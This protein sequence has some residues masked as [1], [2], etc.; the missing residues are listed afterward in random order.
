MS[1]H[2]LTNYIGYTSLYRVAGKPGEEYNQMCLLFFS[3]Y[4]KTE[5]EEIELEETGHQPT[6]HCQSR[7]YCHMEGATQSRGTTR[8]LLPPVCPAH[9]GHPNE[10]S[11]LDC[12]YCTATYVHVL[13]V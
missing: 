13:W 9:P 6:H 7:W 12:K 2:T 8:S 1:V 4:A 5:L 10:G 3:S 11:G